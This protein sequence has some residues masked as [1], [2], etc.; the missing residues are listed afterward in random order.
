VGEVYGLYVDPDWWG[1]GIG[2]ELLTDATRALA[3]AGF[4]SAILWTLAADELARRFY[5]ARDW[6]DDGVSEPHES[7]AIVV[8]YSRALVGYVDP[9][10]RLE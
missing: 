4:E 2:G 9:D 7:G 8:R 6:C 10:L 5:E 1:K 3:E